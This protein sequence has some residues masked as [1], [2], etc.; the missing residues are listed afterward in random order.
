[1]GHDT[2]TFSGGGGIRLKTRPMTFHI[3]YAFVDFGIL[4]LSHQIGLGL[5][6]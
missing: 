3:D 5:E 4:K 1:M 6:F 2:A